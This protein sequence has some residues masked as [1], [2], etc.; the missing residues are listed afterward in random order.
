MRF[1]FP[2][3]SLE[4]ASDGGSG[5]SGLPQPGQEATFWNSPGGAGS[6]LPPS[7]EHNGIACAGKA[8]AINA[9]AR[10][11]LYFSGRSIISRWRRR[12]PGGE[13][14]YL[15][16]SNVRRAVFGVPGHG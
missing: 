13:G 16:C 3:A 14:G 2:R 9:G 12:G 11:W 1:G 10:S 8:A 4:N 15:R 7:S 6:W 5:P